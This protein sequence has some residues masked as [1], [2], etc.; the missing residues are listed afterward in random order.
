MYYICMCVFIYIYIYG[1]RERDRYIGMGKAD[2]RRTRVPRVLRF[3]ALV[4]IR[5]HVRDCM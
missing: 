3:A 5:L 4:A 2:G 1:E